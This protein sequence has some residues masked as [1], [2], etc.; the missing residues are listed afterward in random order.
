MA[1]A[2]T[3]ADEV[4]G[5]F[6]RYHQREYPNDD[7]TRDMIEGGYFSHSRRYICERHG[8]YGND[9]AAMTDED[10]DADWSDGDEYWYQ[11]GQFFGGHT[12][13]Y[14]RGY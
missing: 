14:P 12:N 9:L 1:A 3:T 13:T 8:Y 6:L 10:I 11:V 7:M 2:L 5:R 4:F